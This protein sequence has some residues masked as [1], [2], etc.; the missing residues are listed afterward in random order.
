MALPTPA[1]VYWVGSVRV[2]VFGFGASDAEP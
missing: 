1:A 2:A